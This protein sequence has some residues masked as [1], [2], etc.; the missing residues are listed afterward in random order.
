MIGGKI[1]GDISRIAQP[2]AGVHLKVDAPRRPAFGLREFSY[3]V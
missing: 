3:A 2:Q 1:S